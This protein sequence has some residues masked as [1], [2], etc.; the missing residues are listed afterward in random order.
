MAVLWYGLAGS[1]SHS[2]Y[3]F[4]IRTPGHHRRLDSKT[5][6]GLLEYLRRPGHGAHFLDQVKPLAFLSSDPT[7]SSQVEV[8]FS[9]D[10][11]PTLSSGRPHVD[12]R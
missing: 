11:V 4:T 12:G 2:K 9:F 7:P 8:T 1:E 5:T 10:A 3:G 6:S